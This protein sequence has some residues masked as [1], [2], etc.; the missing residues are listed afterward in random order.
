[1]NCNVK[2]STKENIWYISYEVTVLVTHSC[3]TFWDPMGCSMPDSSVHGIL[4][5]RIMELET[6]SLSRGSSLPKYWTWTSWIAGRFFTIW[7]TREVYIYTVHINNTSVQFSHSV[8]SD[9]WRS[10]E[11]QHA[12]PPCPSPTPRV[13]PNPCP[14]CRWCHPTISSSVVPFSS[15]PHLSQHQGLFQWV[16][17]SHQVAKV[18]EFQLQ[19]QSFK[20]TPKTDIL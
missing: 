4:Q 20:R 1:M 15:C 9:S 2:E 7:A 12:R 19:H 6:I 17:S 5:A 3:L 11:P 18:L 16:S 10:H 14:L 13:L 8:K